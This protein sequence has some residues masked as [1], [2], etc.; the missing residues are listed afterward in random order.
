[1]QQLKRMR[2]VNDKLVFSTRWDLYHRE[3][4]KL[5]RAQD[6]SRMTG[7]MVKAAESLDHE[8]HLG[9]GRLLLKAVALEADAPIRRATLPNTTR[10]S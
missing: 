7:D 6:K 3:Q 2:Q 4:I 5:S 10:G 1:M 8:F 9:E